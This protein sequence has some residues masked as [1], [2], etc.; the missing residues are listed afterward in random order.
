MRKEISEF[1][2]L[3]HGTLPTLMKKTIALNHCLNNTNFFVISTFV[4]YSPFYMQTT[5][6]SKIDSPRF[7][8]VSNY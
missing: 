1:E 2:K 4:P 6:N 8:V 7:Y 5:D 3:N